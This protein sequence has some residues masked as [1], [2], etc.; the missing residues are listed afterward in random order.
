MI[1]DCRSRQ[2]GA[3]DRDFVDLPVKVAAG[4]APGGVST[5]AP[6][7]VISFCTGC[8]IRALEIAVDVESQASRRLCRYYV[9]PPPV[10]VR[11]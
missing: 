10:V 2:G 1:R 5:Y 3:V 4:G 9:V 11:C 7:P 6:V 8:R